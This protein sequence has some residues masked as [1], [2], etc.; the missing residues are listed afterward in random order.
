M[1]VVTSKPRK[2]LIEAAPP[3]EAIESAIVHAQAILAV[4]GL[5]VHKRRLLDVCIWNVTEAEGKCNVRYWSVGVYALVDQLGS[6]NAVRKMRPLPLRHEHV[7]TR[8]A[9]INTMLSDPSTVERVL[10]ERCVA[11][12]VTTDEHLRLKD[13]LEGFDRYHTAAIRV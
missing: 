5:N 10:R 6:L 2:K 12:L 13:S 11:C 8:A 4:P 7:N 1:T 9:L 3:L